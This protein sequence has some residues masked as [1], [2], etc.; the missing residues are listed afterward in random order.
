MLDE[1]CTA[2][3][4]SAAYALLSCSNMHPSDSLRRVA[5][6]GVA[7]CA[8]LLGCEVGE[9]PPEAVPARELFDTRAWPALSVACAGCHASQPSIDF[10]APG[11]PDGA[12]AAVFDH[13]PSLIDTA[14]PASS[15]LLGMGK[16]TGP[17]FTP[18]DA[19]AVLAW[20]EAETAERTM[21]PPDPIVL[22]PLALQLGTVNQIALPADGALLR[23]TPADVGGALSLTDLE[24]H[25]GPRGLRA[26]HPVFSSRPA[27][28][29]PIVDVA[30]RYRDVDLDLAANAA[31]RLGGGAALFPTFQPTDPI[32]IHFRKLE[33]P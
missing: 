24:L 5:S 21:P 7:A 20:L 19:E 25:A 11:T 28:G 15:L 2:R 8:T 29:P 32:T 1:I 14:S 31:E 13:Q 30:D 27:D 4:A 9:R 26:V 22:G 18:L 10:L 23:F 12:Y 6:L 17:A 3:R 16:H 33:A